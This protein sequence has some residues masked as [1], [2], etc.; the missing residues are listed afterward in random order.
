MAAEEEHEEE[1]VAA[2]EE[3]E[4]V[5]VSA[6]EGNDLSATRL[7]RQRLRRWQTLRFK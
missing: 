4:E 2:E 6:E 7:P 1:V 5:V 3:R